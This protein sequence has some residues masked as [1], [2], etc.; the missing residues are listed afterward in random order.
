MTQTKQLPP[1]PAASLFP[2]MGE[3]ALRELAE[4]IKANGQIEPIWTYEGQILDGRNRYLA[5]GMAGVE[6]RMQE[7]NGTGSPVAFV[8]SINLHRRHLTPEQKAAV[9]L[10]AMPLFA[11]EAERR[12]LAGR[13]DPGHESLPGSGERRRDNSKRAAV[14]AAKAAGAG[15][16]A[17]Q[18]LNSIKTKAPEVVEQVKQG[19]MKI[20]EAKQAAALP[21]AERAEAVERIK[22]GEKARNV[23]PKQE[24][25]AKAPKAQPRI[26]SRDRQDA[27]PD[28][29]PEHRSNG[30]DGDSLGLP[31]EDD[32]VR[33]QRPDPE[34][35]YKQP[36]VAV[37]REIPKA[38]EFVSLK[39][40]SDA[41][42][43]VADMWTEFEK[44]ARATLSGECIEDAVTVGRRHAQQVLDLVGELRAKVRTRNA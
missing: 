24:K 19:R 16:N 5:C 33:T 6:P 3:V 17:V 43:P 27:P 4:D 31:K 38:P 30:W 40:K 15:I 2:M 36:S 44:D 13:P 7:Y 14:Q 41:P 9:A 18:Q 26:D 35:G 12:M 1:H 34:I 39:G 21:D 37:A 29:V 25:P 42:P 22:Q 8:L 10:D 20:G 11:A 28:D 23:L 32:D